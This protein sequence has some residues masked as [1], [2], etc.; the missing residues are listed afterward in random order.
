M[1]NGKFANN[2]RVNIGN[3]E[4]LGVIFCCSH[5]CFVQVFDQ[6]IIKL[7]CTFLWCSVLVMR[8]FSRYGWS[9]L[10]KLWRLSH[11]IIWHTI[12]KWRTQLEKYNYGKM[13]NN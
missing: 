7:N 5:M 13:N 6:V 2:Q 9:E 1:V 4:L 11:K 10:I 8:V 3:G 12:M